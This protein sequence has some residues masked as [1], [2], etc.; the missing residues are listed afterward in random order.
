MTWTILSRSVFVRLYLM[1]A[2]QTTDIQMIVGLGNP[3]SEYQD[4]RHN[5]GQWFV[6]QLAS[7]HSAKFKLESRYKAQLAKV[8]IANKEVRLVLPTTYMNESGQ[9]I[10]PIA[11]FFKLVPEQ[12]LVVHDELDLEPGVAR[13]KQG[14]GHGG[15]N[16]LRDTISRLGNS[17][18][19]MR[20]R[21]GI[22]HPGDKNK[23]TTYVL[24]SPSAEE[25]IAIQNSIDAALN[26]IEKVIAGEIQN[27]M[28]ALHTQ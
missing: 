26:V 15:H 1:P 21:I 19:F 24:K 3:G 12:I 4:T 20:L 5:V 8:V 10:A 17:K 2:T 9:S 16:G 22:G 23:V 18:E 25:K 13:L 28:T 7:Q 11:N 6:Q 14:G 27:A